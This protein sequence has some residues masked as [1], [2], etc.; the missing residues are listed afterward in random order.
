MLGAGIIGLENQFLVF[1]RVAVLH[2]FYC[3][4]WPK[5]WHVHK[6]NILISLVTNMSDQKLYGR[7]GHNDTVSLGKQPRIKI[8]CADSQTDQN[9]CWKQ[10]LLC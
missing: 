5:S 4:K 2:R 9:L 6:M 8:Y 1:L 7:L 3:L 10:K